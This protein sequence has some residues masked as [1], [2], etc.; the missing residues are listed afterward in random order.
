SRPAARGS[1]IQIY[2][3]GEG[4][5]IPSGVDGK[6][7]SP[8][9]PQP[10]APVSVLIGGV[11]AELIYAGAAPTLVAGVLQVNVRLPLTVA[12]GDNVPLQIT[13]GNL[14]SQAGITVAVQ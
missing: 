1:I 9:L 14:Q 8:P 10:V 2:A 12:P 11:Q 5:T 4:Q 3:T 13:V 7:G 6:P